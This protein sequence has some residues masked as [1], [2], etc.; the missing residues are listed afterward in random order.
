MIAKNSVAKPRQLVV[1]LAI[2]LFCVPLNAQ[3]NQTRFFSAYDHQAL[4]VSTTAVGL[5]INKINATPTG[6]QAVGISVE[7]SSGT[8]CPIRFYIDGTTAV[9]TAGTQVDYQS[10]MIIYSIDNI[11]R[12]SAIRSG[13]VDAILQII[14]YR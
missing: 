2:L 7:C 8:T 6:T 14:Y 1:L 5:D 11:R 9:T 4:T 10:Q 13:T 3:N 12:F